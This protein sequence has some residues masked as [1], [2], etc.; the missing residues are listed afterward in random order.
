MAIPCGRWNLDDNMYI[1]TGAFILTIL[2]WLIWIWASFAAMGDDFN[3]ASV[4]AVNSNSL[5]GSQAGVLG[6]ILFNFGFVTTVPSWINEKKPGVSTNRSLWYS[7]T[8]CVVIFF[9]VGLPGAYAYSDVLQGPVT[10]SCARMAT[11]SDYNCANDMLQVLSTRALVPKSWDHPFGRV[12][13]KTS[14]YLFPIVAV[15]SS[16]PV[17]SIVIKYNM[18]E[19][20]F[21]KTT[22]FL[23]G[24][25]FPWIFAF[26][27]LYMPSV[28]AQFVNFTSLV[29]VSFTDF[30]VPWALYVELQKGRDSGVSEES[31]FVAGMSEEARE[32]EVRAHYA[33]PRWLGMSTSAKRIF[34]YSFMIFLGVAAVV[35]SVLTVIQ[36]TYT[37]DLQVCALVGN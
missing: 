7:T 32:A 28:L 14:V 3:T 35:A 15:I 29:F 10:A 4:V 6:N 23:W 13:L 33:I 26:P 24:V 1:Q 8:F 20:G 17:F 31:S 11:E 25:I 37:L 30:I 5:T 27:L 19:N 22:S 9:A 21:S 16:I 12:V 36:G 2:C 18:M 34:S